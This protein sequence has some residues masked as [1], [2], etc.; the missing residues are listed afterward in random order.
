MLKKRQGVL[1]AL[2]LT[3]IFT[4]C[5]LSSGRGSLKENL[6]ESFD[7]WMQSLSQ[8]VLTKEEDLQGQK[9]AGIDAYT[10]SYTASY[11][12]FNG[13]EVLFG[14]TSWK[15]ENGNRLEVTYVLTIESGTA[16]LCWI[17]GNDVYIAGS[18]SAEDTKEY[19]ISS[20]DNYLV[21]KGENFTGSLAV[22]VKDPEA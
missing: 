7:H 15:R 22:T 17:S 5:S 9:E 19:S 11:R 21:L 13:E 2:C 4:G 20:G 6:L 16:Q 14:G 3:V 10:G 18:E 12:K 1:L 8:C